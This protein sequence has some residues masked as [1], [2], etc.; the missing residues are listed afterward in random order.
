MQGP[1]C[2]LLAVAAPLFLATTAA[3]TEDGDGDKVSNG[4]IVINGST[5]VPGGSGPEDITIINGSTVGS[6]GTTTGS[7][8]SP[9]PENITV[10]NGSTVGGST[11]TSSKT[12]AATPA[13]TSSSAA[14]ASVG[15]GGL[16]AGV[17]GLTSVVVGLVGG[18]VLIVTAVL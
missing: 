14:A 8:P 7:V 12:P 1:R 10:I 3:A 11:A 2:L 13:A 15:H 18:A 6:G 4:P 5:V 16:G 9:T 17:F